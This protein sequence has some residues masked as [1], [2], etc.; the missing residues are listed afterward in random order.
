MVLR[1]FL[2]L[3]D[4]LEM[5]PQPLALRTISAKPFNTSSRL[6]NRPD[7]SDRRPP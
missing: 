3:T 2:T 6:K 5:T 4:M 7:T 1:A